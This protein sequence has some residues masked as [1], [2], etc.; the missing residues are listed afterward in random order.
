MRLPTLNVGSSF[1]YL[2]RYN[3]VQRKGLWFL[4]TCLVSHWH[5]IYPVAATMA[6]I[7]CCLWITASFTLSC[8]LKLSTSP[9]ILKVFSD[10]LGLMRHSDSW[11]SAHV[12]LTS[13]FW[14]QPSMDYSD[15][16]MQDNL[17]NPLY[18]NIHSFNSISL[19]NFD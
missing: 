13:T 11:L 2:L 10:S 4:P 19:E 17:V 15:C 7:H 8:E 9:G 16:S 1:W 18:I 3:G 14:R 12:Y 5:F 6:M